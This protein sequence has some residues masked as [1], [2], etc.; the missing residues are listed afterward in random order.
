MSVIIDLV[1]VAILVIFL[2]VGMKKGLVQMLLPLIA[3]VI[4]VLLGLALRSPVRALLSKT[5]MEEKIAA[6][7]TNIVR[8]ALDKY[9]SQDDAETAEGADSGEAASEGDESGLKEAEVTTKSPEEIKKEE[10]LAKED[11]EKAVSKTSIPGYL[12]EK[13]KAW[14]AKNSGDVYGEDV[15]TAAVIGKKAASLIVDLIAILIAAIVVIIV[16]LIIKF[17]IKRTRELNVPVLHQLDTVGGALFGLALGAAIL[18]GATFVIG[19]LASCGY[20]TDFAAAMKKS[21][22]G[23]FL[24]DHNLVG[25]I[26][27]MFK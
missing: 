22:I 8:K 4:A 25:K 23:G 24:Y 26:A 12:V 18:Y 11:G 27:A 10:E 17:I 5:P 19:V 2:I 21:V 13:L 20:L 9:G 1:I 14:A 3:I 6:S 7:A 16:I 15:D